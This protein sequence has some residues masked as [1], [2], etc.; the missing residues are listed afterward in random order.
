MANRRRPASKVPTACKACREVELHPSDGH[1][2]C[3]M[4]LGS[5]HDPF[6][7]ST[8]E[9]F[10]QALRDIRLGLIN[11]SLEKG[12][13]SPDWQKRL[14]K[15][16]NDVLTNYKKKQSQ[17]D[18]QSKIKSAELVTSSSSESEE[19]NENQNQNVA[20][21][22]QSPKDKQGEKAK[23]NTSPKSQPDSNILTSNV[24]SNPNPCPTPQGSNQ[25][26]ATWQAGIDKTVGQL[27]L[28]L[29]S[30]LETL[31]QFT[32]QQTSTKKKSKAK[33]HKSK[34]GKDF[35]SLPPPAK[36]RRATETAPNPDTNQ[37]ELSLSLPEELGFDLTE[38]GGA[39]PLLK[40]L[41]LGSQTQSLIQCLI[42]LPT[43]LIMTLTLKWIL[44]LAEGIRENYIFRVFR[45]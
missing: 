41:S 1:F 12:T 5:A 45:H 36:K 42:L 37:E 34:N 31:Q 13:W 9:D 18:K 27:S 6:N 11:E 20:K 2:I 22:V 29:K 17:K 44:I 4:C 8:C 43:G 3:L 24:P 30:V 10:P 23:N 25:E 38:H 35:D 21:N 15:V 32:Q 19:E 40:Y 7:C 28:G 14:K 39:P 16:E 33:K 26:F